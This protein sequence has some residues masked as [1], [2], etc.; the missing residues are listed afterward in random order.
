MSDRRDLLPGTRVVQTD[1]CLMDEQGFIPEWRPIGDV[2]G[3]D[4]VGQVKV[5]F[6]GG[7][8]LHFDPRDLQVADD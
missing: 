4:G 3:W 5:S 6:D 2:L 1:D 8:T 7:P